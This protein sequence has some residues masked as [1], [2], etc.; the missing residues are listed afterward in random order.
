MSFLPAFGSTILNQIPGANS[1]P[2]PVYI[3]PTRKIVGVST[4]GSTGSAQGSGTGA[5]FILKSTVATQTTTI[6][7]DAVVEEVHDD[8]VVATQHPVEQGA[9][10]SDHAYKEPAILDV[11]YAWSA[12]SQQNLTDALSGTAALGSLG[13]VADP[14]AFLKGIYQQL[15]GLAIGRVLC[16]VYTGKRLYTNMLIIDIGATTDRETENSF[17]AHIRFQEIL[18]ATTQIVTVPANANQ[19]NP[20]ATNSPVGVG[21]QSLQPAPS[22]NVP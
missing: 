11:T 18:M 22:L 19:A 2:A 9:T 12:G 7:A 21:T 5:D 13:S 10:I 4:A 3:K 6:I 1:L 16:S 20:A 14:M 8:K 15:L 17:I